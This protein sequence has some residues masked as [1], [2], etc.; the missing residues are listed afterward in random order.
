MSF[1]QGLFRTF[2]SGAFIPFDS[3][4]FIPLDSSLSAYLC[5]VLI[6]PSLISI[7]SAVTHP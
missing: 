3:G 7:P 1:S 4:A 6:L 5:D 2:S